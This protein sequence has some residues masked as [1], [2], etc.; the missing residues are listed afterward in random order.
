MTDARLLSQSLG[1]SAG[2]VR[3]RPVARSPCA[4]G[5]QDRA[6]PP[7]ADAPRWRPARLALALLALSLIVQ[8]SDAIGPACADP[9]PFGLEL[10]K[11][12]QDSIGARYR[13]IS[14]GIDR[15]GGGAMFELDV[16]QIEFDGL[17]RVTLVFGADRILAAVLTRFSRD[18]FPDLLRLLSGKY[19]LVER[20]TPATGDWTA[21]FSDGD[22]EIVLSAPRLR[23]HAQLDYVRRSLRASADR[24]RAADRVQASE[25]GRL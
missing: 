12:T 11:A 7:S 13:L 2:A 3:C 21:R 23:F 5:S 24:R 18:R 19:S 1:H 16:T 4:A 14:T 6:T 17:E 15:Y 25:R 10:G 22:T 8:L 9:A 20:R